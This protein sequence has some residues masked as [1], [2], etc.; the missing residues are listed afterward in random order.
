MQLEL[1]MPGKSRKMGGGDG[2]CKR[3]GM[4][5]ENTKRESDWA[6]AHLHRK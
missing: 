6:N 1:P 5:I 3:N 4:E 2:L